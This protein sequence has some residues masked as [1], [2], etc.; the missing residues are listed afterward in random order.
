MLVYMTVSI[1]RKNN[2][3]KIN[4]LPSLCIAGE[5]Q[6]QST[7]L[8]GE[9]RFYKKKTSEC[10]EKGAVPVLRAGLTSED[11]PGEHW[12]GESCL[13][14][15]GVWK[16]G[17]HPEQKAPG[18]FWD[19]VNQNQNLKARNSKIKN[20]RITIIREGSGYQIGWSFGKV[21]KGGG[22]IFNPK[23]YVFQQFFYL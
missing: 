20:P 21:P 13:D 22:V 10:Y 14:I 19:I 15:S 18:R 2:W 5:T 1:L 7:W 9:G 23:G 3:G 8:T 16:A 17:G 4:W 12:Q 6:S 11:P